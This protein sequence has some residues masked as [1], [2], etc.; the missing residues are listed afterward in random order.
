VDVTYPFDTPAGSDLEPEGVRLLAEGPMV[1]ALMNGHEVWLALGYHVVRQALSDPRFSREA[2]AGP[3]GPALNPAGTNPDFL[4]SMDPPRHTR[5]RHLMARA[6]SRSTVEG[7]EPWIHKLVDGLLDELAAHDKPADLV[8]LVAE[9]LPIM[10]ICQLL[11]IPTEDRAKF[12]YWAGRMVADTAY[13]PTDIAEAMGQSSAYLNELIAVKRQA[14]DDA[15]ISALIGVTD[16]GDYL[17]ESELTSNIQLLLIAGHETMVG[18]IGNCI[19]TLFQ[20]PQQTKL[21]AEHPEL[22]PQAV[23]ELL[24]HARLISSDLPLI[25]TADV[26]LGE[27]TVRAG[28]AVFP[29]IGVANRDP[30]VFPEPHRFDITRT[31][32][33]PHLAFAYGP[34]Y[35]LGA[36]LAHLQLQILIGSLLDRFP[37]LAPAVEIADLPWKAGLAIRSLSALPVTW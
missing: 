5:V 27:T 7:L 24:R 6:F 37:T 12:R 1:R 8:T 13:T 26:L 20:H 25:A 15:L 32:P 29:L 19:V 10:V 22:L 33:A 23:D 18:Q 3:G 11:G 4:V 36:A 9:P 14:P 2:A 30:D 28:E 17:T 16:E 21:L 31:G 35:C 34:H